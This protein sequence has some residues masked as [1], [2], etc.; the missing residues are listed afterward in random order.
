MRDCFKKLGGSPSYIY[1]DKGSEFIN[2]SFKKLLE[3]NGTEIVYTLNHANFAER[4]IRTLKQ[5]MMKKTSETGRPWTELLGPFLKAYNSEQRP[6]T[7]MTPNEASKDKNSADVRTNLL[8]SAKRERKYP[9]L[10]EGDQVR[11]MDKHGGGYG[12]Q[13]I[14]SSKW[15]DEKYTI[16]SVEV[17]LG[18][19]HFNIEG[20]GSFLRHELLKA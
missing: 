5:Y 6:A 18:M 14:T 20:K 13:K 17:S 11:L 16:S 4:L 1:C 7:G 3:E 10:K 12:S 15:S 19:K 8:L 2:E 9:P